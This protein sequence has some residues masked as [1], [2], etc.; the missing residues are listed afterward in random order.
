MYCKIEGQR[1]FCAEGC[2]GTILI[3]GHTK[4]SLPDTEPDLIVRIMK[5]R[6]LL[7]ILLKPIVGAKGSLNGIVHN[8]GLRL[9][10]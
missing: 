3:S 8:L 2:R 1:S 6:I 5:A 10:L 4:A 7:K 9:R